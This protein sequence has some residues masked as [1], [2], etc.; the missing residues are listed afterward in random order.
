MLHGGEIAKREL[1]ADGIPHHEVFD[2]LKE[3]L[4]VKGSIIGCVKQLLEI[5]L[6][7]T[8]NR[9]S[10]RILHDVIT[11]CTFIVAFEKS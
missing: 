3:R 7:K 10:F 6:E 9:R 4:D 5:F 1:L 11:M 8:E 2:D